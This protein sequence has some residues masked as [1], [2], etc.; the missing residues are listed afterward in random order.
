MSTPDKPFLPKIWG[1]AIR[2]AWDHWM[3]MTSSWLVTEKEGEMRED[4][5]MPSPTPEQIVDPVFQAI[6]QAI[7][8]W[9]VNVPEYYDGYCGANGS[10]VMLIVDALKA[11]TLDVGSPTCLLDQAAVAQ[12]LAR[13]DKQIRR[14]STEIFS[15]RITKHLDKDDKTAVRRQTL[16]GRVD[17]LSSM[18]ALGPTDQSF[19]LE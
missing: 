18:A 2:P 12:T 3:S 9:D 1:D 17:E 14:L 5:E 10:H 16:L 7:K 19:F 13:M 6:W 15:T 11:T 8:T 4:K